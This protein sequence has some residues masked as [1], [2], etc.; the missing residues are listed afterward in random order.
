MA[1]GSTQT[2]SEMSTKKLP[3]VEGGRRARPD[4]LTAIC[5]PIDEC[6]DVSQLYGPP[7]S[8][9]GIVLP[10]IAS[11]HYTSSERVGSSRDDN[12]F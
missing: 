4:N 1:L 10:F 3:G 9:T 2:L 6:L 7:W 12:V 8:V 5:E 11:K